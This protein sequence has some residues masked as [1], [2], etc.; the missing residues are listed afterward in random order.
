VLNKKDKEYI[1]LIEANQSEVLVFEH[2]GNVYEGIGFPP[3]SLNLK[4]IIWCII[5]IA[6][7]AGF[8]NWVQVLGL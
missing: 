7:I 2:T 1:R 4:L 5:D 8:Y 6:L 3:K